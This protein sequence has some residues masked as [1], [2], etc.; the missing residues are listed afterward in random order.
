MEELIVSKTIMENWTHWRIFR[1]TVRTKVTSQAHNRYISQVHVINGKQRFPDLT[2]PNIF[3]KETCIIF[4]IPGIAW[5]SYTSTILK[6]FWFLACII[7]TSDPFVSPR[8]IQQLVLRDFTKIFLEPQTPS[9][10]FIEVL[11][12]NIIV[13]YWMWC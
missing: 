2:F 6:Y 12:V 10:Y 5:F 13:F 7:F 9:I 4:I 8:V 11:T 3:W 1:T